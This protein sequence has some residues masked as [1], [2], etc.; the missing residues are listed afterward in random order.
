MK[1]SETEPWDIIN[2]FDNEEEVY[3]KPVRIGNFWS[4]NYIEYECNSD[5]NKILPS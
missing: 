3:D 4:N 2:L 1:Q 5:R